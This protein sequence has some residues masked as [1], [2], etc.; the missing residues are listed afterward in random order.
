[1]SDEEAQKQ[2]AY[3]LKQA[4]DTLIVARELRNR[5]G[6]ADAAGILL[7]CASRILTEELGREVAHKWLQK[8]VAEQ[9][10]KW[11]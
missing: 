3:R 4:A 11:N 2:E 5:V 7:G 6:A 9:S 8:L 1:M 10:A